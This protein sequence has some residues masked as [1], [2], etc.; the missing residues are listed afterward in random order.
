MA[1]SPEGAGLRAAARGTVHPIRARLPLRARHRGN[2]GVQGGW[3][4]ARGG[5]AGLDIRMA[6]TQA[7]PIQG[8]PT[9]YALFS[10]VRASR[11]HARSFVCGP[12]HSQIFGES[13]TPHT[14]GR[15]GTSRSSTQGGWGTNARRAG[16]RRGPA[17][18]APCF[19]GL[20]P[21]STLPASRPTVRSAATQP[22]DCK[23]HCRLRGTPRSQAARSERTRGR[24]VLLCAA[25][26]LR[27]ALPG[28]PAPLRSGS[29]APSATE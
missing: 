1:A 14:N 2:R 29:A 11:M 21:R 18:S 3:G 7:T 6:T 22:P 4:R 12:G 25:A 8:I 16:G 5:E 23:R 9:G 19:L 20:L 28:L 15:Y 27:G 17:V 10:C 24:R 13:R 26:R